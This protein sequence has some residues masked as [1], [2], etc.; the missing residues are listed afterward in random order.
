MP[1]IPNE[2]Q[3]A[4]QDYVEDNDLH[5]VSALHFAQRSSGF[6]AGYAAGQEEVTAG[7]T[8]AVIVQSE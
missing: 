1:L 6:R 4:W 2:M 5:E 7:T 3:N 8:A